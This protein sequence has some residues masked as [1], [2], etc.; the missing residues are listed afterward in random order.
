MKKTL[1]LLSLLLGLNIQL[2]ADNKLT[3]EEFSIEPGEEEKVITINLENDEAVSALEFRLWLPEG[4]SIIDDEYGMYVLGVDARLKQK[5]GRVTYTHNVSANLKEEGYYHFMVFST[6]GLNI[7]GNSGPILEIGLTAGANAAPGQK[8]VRLTNVKLGQTNDEGV[9]VGIYPPDAEFNCTIVGEV[10]PVTV[11][12][13]SYEMVYGDALPDFEFTT[14]EGASLEGTPEI[15]CEA[16]SASPVGEYPITVSAGTVTNE[17]VTYVG[18]T[19]TIKKAP[20]TIKA[21][22]YSMKQGEA[23]PEFTATYEGFK[24]TETEETLSTKPTLT[25]TATSASELGEY[26]VTATGAEANNY[27][28]TYEKGMLTVTAADPVTVTATS[29]SITYGDALPEFAFTSEGASLEGQPEISCEATTSSPVGTYPIVIEKG[30]V[31]NYNDTYVN[32][33][34]TITAAPLTIK[35]GSYTIKQGQT[36]PTFTATYEGFKNSETE[37]VLKKQPVLACEA[38]AAS[39]PGTYNVTVSGAEAENYVISYV[40]GTLTVTAA[41]PV[42]VTAT[43]YTITYGDALPEFAFTSEGASLEGQ[44]EISCEATTSSPVGTYP[45][46][47][48]KGSV[49]N[50]NDTYVNGTLTI[51]AAPLT[52]KAGSYTMKQGQTLPTFTAS[53]EGFKNGETED[54]L[55][56]K[57]TISTTATSAS[58][59]GNYEVTVSGAEAVNYVISYVPGV[60]T[61]ELLKGDVNGDGFVT[62]ADVTALVN[63][64]LGRGTL[65]NE[66][67]AYVNDDTK[68]DIQDV[69][70]LI[71][72]IK[73]M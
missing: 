46:I 58:A 41:D 69:A 2:Q 68:I 7:V 67:A 8:K 33:T 60:L 6:D 56:T 27:E 28:I 22:T 55:T 38:T 63:Y 26:E 54:V 17:N 73:K 23:L 51:S 59:P 11:T 31:T 39:A 43:S 32:G 64:I 57:P 44:P 9:V 25:T 1:F 53:Y 47:I 12:A 37:E 48:T 21:G 65:A 36:M 71:G 19:L 4:V 61:V 34:L 70:A 35:A 10:E 52:I 3:V 62:A 50:Y 45:I 72:I 29:Y 20:L 40:P 66:A 16:T 24:N 42:T 49:A 18:G 14:S 5:I 30:G 13:N 15:S